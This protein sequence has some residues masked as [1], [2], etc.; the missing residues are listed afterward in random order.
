MTVWK[1]LYYGRTEIRAWIC[2]VCRRG[3]PMVRAPRIRGRPRAVC[4]GCRNAADRE[5]R[6]RIRAMNVAR[7]L[8][9]TS[10]NADMLQSLKAGAYV[11]NWAH[12]SG[13]EAGLLIIGKSSAVITLNN[14]SEG[15]RVVL[16]L[17]EV[18]RFLGRRNVLVTNAEVALA[19]ADGTSVGDLDVFIGSFELLSWVQADQKWFNSLRHKP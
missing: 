10:R 18:A 19:S 6:V 9:L 16:D 14:S 12:V 17:P 8:G 7:N 4:C 5:R 13:Q 15:F 11:L 3:E 2:R 1:R